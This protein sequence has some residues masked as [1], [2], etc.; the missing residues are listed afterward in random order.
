MSY[1]EEELE[2]RLSKLGVVPEVRKVVKARIIGKTSEDVNWFLDRWL[3]IF[4][5][6]VQPPDEEWKQLSAISSSGRISEVSNIPANGKHADVNFWHMIAVDIHAK[7]ILRLV[8]T[9]NAA[10]LIGRANKLSNSWSDKILVLL[11][12]KFVNQNVV[13]GQ[14]WHLCNLSD[15]LKDRMAGSGTKALLRYLNTDFEGSLKSLEAKI[16]ANMAATYCISLVDCMAREG[17]TE[18]SI[19]MLESFTD[20]PDWAE[21]VQSID[22]FCM[23]I[24]E[25]FSENLPF[26]LIKTFIDRLGEAGLNERAVLL[27]ESFSNFAGIDYLSTSFDDAL[28]VFVKRDSINNV[29]NFITILVDRLSFVGRRRDANILIQKFEEKNIQEKIGDSAKG[30]SNR[31]TTGGQQSVVIAKVHRL[32]SEKRYSESIDLLERTLEISG[33]E[34]GSNQFLEQLVKQR[35]RFEIEGCSTLITRLAQS[36][37]LVQDFPK[38]VVLGESALANILSTDGATDLQGM[39]DSFKR[40]VSQTTSADFAM[41]FADL[42]LRAELPKQG[43]MLLEAYFDVS[44]VPPNFPSWFDQVSSVATGLPPN[45]RLNILDTYAFC[46]AAV[47]FPVAGGKVSELGFAGLEEGVSAHNWIPAAVT[48]LMTRG[49][50]PKFQEDSFARCQWFVDQIRNSVRKMGLSIDDRLHLI[51]RMIPLREEILNLASYWTVDADDLQEQKRFLYKL[52]EWDLELRQRVLL[53]K[54]LLGPSRTDSVAAEDHQPPSEWPYP[55]STDVLEPLDGN[56]NDNLGLSLAIPL[57]VDVRSS[58]AGF[59]IQT[60]VH[61]PTNLSRIASLSDLASESLSGEVFANYLGSET[62]FL[63]IHTQNNVLRWIL[64]GTNVES[65]QVEVVACG[66]S[67][68]DIQRDIQWEIAIH[69]IRCQFHYILERFR[70]QKVGKARVLKAADCFSSNK[71]SLEVTKKNAAYFQNQEGFAAFGRS[72]ETYIVPLS[73]ELFE[74][75]PGYWGR[76]DKYIKGDLAKFRDGQDLKLESLTSEFVDRVSRLACLSNLPDLGKQGIKHLVIAADGMHAAIPWAHLKSGGTPLGQQVDS[77]RFSFSPMIDRLLETIENQRKLEESAVAV[78]GVTSFEE[79]DPKEVERKTKAGE[80]VDCGGVAGYLLHNQLRRSVEAPFRYEAAA[81]SPVAN[82]EWFQHQVNSEEYALVCLMAH[83]DRE[84]RSISF[85]DGAWD[86]IAPLEGVDFLILGSCSTG[87]IEGVLDSDGFCIQL[88][89]SGARSV[90]APRWDV[91]AAETPVF[92]NA[93]AKEYLNL[94]RDPAYN[95]LPRRAIALN[96]VRQMIWQSHLNSSGPEHQELSRISLNTVAAF[97]LY[98]L[99]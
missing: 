90:L 39:V 92:I 22:Q 56:A 7:P 19:A 49:S 1:S 86:G 76:L 63:R 25:R 24:E 42:L 6:A 79:N 68:S 80:T 64:L 61:S 87:H 51:D 5:A 10:V 16:S 34:Y 91:S 67:E 85:R 15:Q 47:G 84:K 81:L 50:D 98:G 11:R 38:A 28:A 14:I 37:Q 21:Q 52:V 33:L 27:A 55:D 82:P 88:L 72:I 73:C 75:D 54:F 8:A 20:G 13:E 35:N 18:E 12:P 26:L 57:N 36:L 53:E 46:L 9:M 45:L 77:V 43:L 41:I 93:V 31:R 65:A 60:E 30:M 94:C 59:P 97:E 95:D 71:E 70:L 96:R 62:A 89:I 44:G 83:G 66:G 58:G 69:E 4:E 32:I 17:R 3:T 29:T 99:G 48:W 78:L 74:C 23:E 40:N 2:T